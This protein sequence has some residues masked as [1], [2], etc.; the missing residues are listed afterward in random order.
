MELQK[1]KRAKAKYRNV[2]NA[3]AERYADI[4][5]FVPH[6]GYHYMKAKYLDAKFEADKPQL[7]VYL[8]HPV[9]GRMRLVAV[10]YAVPQSLSPNAP[11]G[12]PGSA[13]AWDKN[14][15]FGLWTLHTRVWYK[16]PDGIFNHANP[17]IP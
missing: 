5:V 15:D 7:L 13:D 4:N 2:N 10:E 17:L 6:M 16:N 14:D 12:F 9:T 1:A 11:E 8:P 3:I